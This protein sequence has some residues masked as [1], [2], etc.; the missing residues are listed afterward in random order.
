[1]LAYHRGEIAQALDGLTEA[2]RRY[3]L[4]R[5]WENASTPELKQAFGYDP[6]ALWSRS[7][8]S[9]AREALAESLAH[10]NAA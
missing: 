3:V 1:M 4:L 8:R 9:A 6:K 5:F 10:L 2:Q 7:G